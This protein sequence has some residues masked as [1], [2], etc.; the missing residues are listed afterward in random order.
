M[1]DRRERSSGRV[2]IPEWEDW[3]VG[4]H[5]YWYPGRLSTAGLDGDSVKEDIDL[6]EGKGGGI[7]NS[8]GVLDDLLSCTY[9]YETMSI[10][11]IASYFSL[12]CNRCWPIKT[13]RPRD[14]FPYRIEN[15][16]GALWRSHWGL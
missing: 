13:W 16:A 4:R 11:F 7:K 3:G 15:V 10:H 9:E 1:Y 6:V 12:R 8:K 2:W 5:L 14:D